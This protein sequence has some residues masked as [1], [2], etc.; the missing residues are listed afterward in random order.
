MGSKLRV[1]YEGYAPGTSYWSHLCNR[2]QSLW[3]KQKNRDH[4][5]RRYPTRWRCYIDHKETRANRQAMRA[6]RSSRW[7]EFVASVCHC[8]QLWVILE[9]ERSPTVSDIPISHVQLCSWKLV[10]TEAN[11]RLL[12]TAPPIV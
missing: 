2:K 8:G 7:R 1:T 6:K 3:C 12:S 4:L 9:I 11:S 10:T 5:T